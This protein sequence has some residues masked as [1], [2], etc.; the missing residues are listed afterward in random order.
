MR[1]E[2]TE[3]HIKLLGKFYV[4]WADYAYDGAPAV[5][6]KRPFGN[7]DVPRDIY[8]ILNADKLDTLDED[9]WEEFYDREHPELMSIFREMDKVVQIALNCAGRGHVV[10]PG[11]YEQVELYNQRDWKRVVK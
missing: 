8:E 6:S 7:Q 5:D 2:V 1:F 4:G 11:E 3:D 10:V 9:F